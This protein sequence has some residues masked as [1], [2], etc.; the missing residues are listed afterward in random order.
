MTPTDSRLV[1]FRL[2]L[3]LGSGRAP[4]N[5]LPTH[6]R[7]RLLF[8]H[9]FSGVSLP[10][11]GRA[12]FVSCCWP[13]RRIHASRVWNLSPA[14]LDDTINKTTPE[15]F[16]RLQDLISFHLHTQARCLVSHIGSSRL[17]RDWSGLVC[18]FSPRIS[19]K[20]WIS[21]TDSSS[22]AHWSPCLV[23]GLLKGL[24]YSECLALSLRPS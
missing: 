2:I 1:W 4:S 15:Y 14:P 3:P 11:P 16:A 10:H 12:L 20:T 24:L 6:H 13:L 17:S 9:C 22:Q 7:R 21:E 19:P 18:I 23:Y 8:R 5:C